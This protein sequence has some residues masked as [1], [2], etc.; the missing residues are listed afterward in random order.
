MKTFTTQSGGVYQQTKRTDVMENMNNPNQRLK[1]VGSA[2]GDV[3]VVED[4]HTKKRRPHW[5]PSGERVDLVECGVTQ[6]HVDLMAFSS[7]SV[8]IS[9]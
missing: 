2:D 5:K 3:W 1:L 7:S 8:D 4:L 6:T 9:A